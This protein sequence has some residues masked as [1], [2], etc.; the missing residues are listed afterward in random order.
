MPYMSLPSEEG[1]KVLLRKTRLRRS[2]WHRLL[3]ARRKMIRPFLNKFTLTELG[4]MKLIPHAFSPEQIYGNPLVTGDE[5][6]SLKT[7]GIFYAQPHDKINNGDGKFL[8]SVPGKGTFLVWGISRSGEWILA[9]MELD[10]YCYDLKHNHFACAV[11][12][13]RMTKS[14]VAT[15]VRK[16]G[17]NP[18]Y[19]LKDI[20]R[21]IKGLTNV[22][23]QLYEQALELVRVIEAEETAISLIT[24]K[25]PF[26]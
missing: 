25:D 13:I 5:G 15:I 8:Y 12:A 6:L 3:E 9:E 21:S 2:D 20:D 7:Q 4:S 10:S 19:M 22:R 26:W 14:D 16:T 1:L 23:G 24:K 18:L 11:T 17:G